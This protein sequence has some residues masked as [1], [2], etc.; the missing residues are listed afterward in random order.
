M[1]RTTTF[2][3]MALGALALT[4]A[5]NDQP[6][7]PP[8]AERPGVNLL[9]SVSSS[10]FQ[11]CANAD[12][13]PNCHWINS[14]L[15]AEKSQYAE[16]E[17]IAERFGLHGL[18]TAAGQDEHTLVFKYG[19]LKGNP[20]DH[21]GNYDLIVGYDATLGS[22]VANVCLGET[23]PVTAFCTGSA[24]KPAFAGTN[25]T[26][27]VIPLAKFTNSIAPNSF[28]SPYKP[29]IEAAYASFL[30]ANPGGI[31]FDVF[32]GEVV[33]FG[34]VVYTLGGSDILATFTVTFKAYP[35]AQGDVLLAWGGRFASSVEWGAGHGAAGQSGSPFHFKMESISDY[36]TSKGVTTLQTIGIG[37]LGNNVSGNVV[38]IAPPSLGITKTPA[39]Q[40]VS[41]GSP[42]SWTVTLSNTGAGPASNAVINDNL[43]TIAGVTYALGAG[44]DATCSLTN[45]VLECGPKDLLTGES[46]IAVID[47][48]TTA[49]QGCGAGTV[50]NTATGQATGTTTVQAQATVTLE[51]GSLSL[52]KTPTSQTVDAGQPF[53][54]TVTLTNAGPGTAFNAVI[55][56]NLPVVTGITYALDASS[57]A[58]C[59]LAANVLE[60]G[61]KDLA[62]DATLVAKINATTTPTTA[63][64][65]A[66]TITNTATGQADGSTAIQS[67]ATV[68]LDCGS[69]SITKT[70]VSQTIDAGQPFSWTVTLT[71]AGPGSALAA[72]IND[73]LPAVDGI[74]Y[75]LDASSAASCSLTAGVLECGPTDLAK[76]AT[77]VAKINATTTPTTALCTAGT[78][79]NTA[80]G[81]ATAL[82]QVTAQANVTFQCGSLSIT[83]TPASQTI[84]AG[85]PFSW[86]VTLKNDGPGGAVAAVINDTPP[87]VSGI[88][89]SLDA[90]SDATCSLTA[91][92]LEC[93]P[94]AL[95]KDATIV[96]KINATTSV[97][98]AVCAAGTITNT[99]TGDA[100]ALSQ[101]TAQATVTLNCPDL[102]ITK[103]PDEEGDDG[104]EVSPGGTATFKI[105]VKN[106]GAGVA[107][108]VLITDPLPNGVLEWTPDQTEC[109][110][111][112]GSLSCSGGDLATLA[113]GASFIVNVSAEIPTDY[114]VPTGTGNA[115]APLVAS[116]GNLA[117]PGTEVDW[118]NAGIVCQ[119]TGCKLDASGA[120]DNSFGNGTKED[121]PVPSVVTGSIPPNKSDLTRFY[122]T[123]RKVAVSG[124][125]HDF[126][127]LAW[128]RVQDPSGTTNMDF[129]INQNPTTQLS[130]NGVTVD[131]KAGDVLIKYDL[132]RGGTNPTLGF[133]RW[134]TAATA[135]GK[136][137]AQACQASNTFP[138]WGKVQAI[139]VGAFQASINSAQELDPIP[140]PVDGRTLSA[141]TFGEAGI[142]LQGS[143]IFQPGVCLNFG[144]AY[145]KS[146]SSDSFTAAVKD[147]VAPVT[148]SVQV[149]QNKL[150]NNT[151]S[152]AADG[153]AAES[154]DGQIKV[155]APTASLFTD[156]A[157]VRFAQAGVAGTLPT[158]AVSTGAVSTGVVSTGV[159][160][161]SVAS[162]GV[163]SI[164]FVPAVAAFDAG[165]RSEVRRAGRTPARAAER[166]GRGEPRRAQPLRATSD[167]HG[168]V[169]T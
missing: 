79:T 84:D 93:G 151:A 153:L 155:V 108:N 135:D 35:V 160:T 42:F 156:P 68:V 36:V 34:D 114:L 111:T 158:G 66:G 154:D 107:T 47:A 141:R 49:G 19:F 88:V 18:S 132:S 112:S 39:S 11:Q 95:A 119:T 51:C 121:T 57:D 53:S 126:L 165:G 161:A 105:E 82:S 101:V 152:A 100:T 38:Q 62:K 142:D 98:A 166:V 91:G 144:S 86:T 109:S 137:P 163:A 90:S 8:G 134:V 129:E 139:G 85:Q 113:A 145:L 55:N 106:I 72:V 70:P 75:S 21:H 10:D 77:I 131:R 52:A 133:H 104:Y 122:A 130:T 58:T 147:F 54:W 56:D 164:N 37:A 92:V 64:C 99:A 40:T 150:L 116:D 29:I 28:M 162:A 5:C 69:L 125:T 78:I 168:S 46:M 146:R 117:A 81:D 159:G 41:A 140:P 4:I 24:L 61:T 128:E 74:V 25:H 33:S 169:A 123:S 136:T 115:V 43:P 97:T 65:A 59:S 110:V 71:N 13:G 45:N 167:G 2:V 30:A 157:N 20:P 22:T 67:Q 23:A 32:G 138:C 83:K 14:V 96:A 44:S 15:N 102:Q 103:T 80:T 6:V 7:A 89:Y 1:K 27:A 48:T 60:C 120:T 12:P 31:R 118:A 148:L 124:S 76:D 149:C 9:S 3:G 63:V 143:G 50:T 127:Y 17:A 87:A 73:N 94:S 26:A 16:G